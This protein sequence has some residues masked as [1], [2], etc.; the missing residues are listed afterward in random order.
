MMNI[1]VLHSGDMRSISLGGVDR[2]IKSLILFSKDNEVTVFGTTVVGEHIIGEE[3]QKEYRGRKYKFVAISDNARSPLSVFYMLNE[4][5]WVKK[6]GQYD[7]IYAQRTEYSIPFLM[8]KNKK[9][10]I[11]MIHGSS[12]YSEIGFGKKMAKIHLFMEKMAVSIAAKTFII[13]NRE[14]F[15]VP[16]YKKK[17]AK[18]ANR[19]LYGR[20]PIDTSIYKKLDRNMARQQLKLNNDD[21]IVLFSGRVEHNPKR[22][23]FFPDICK[24]LIR[25]V[26]NLKF[27]V[28]GDGKS[29]ESLVEKIEEMNLQENFHLPGYIDDPNLIAIYN[30]AANVTINIS[31]FEGTCTSNLEAIACGVPVVSTDV[32]DIRECIHENYNGI[33][34]PNNDD[35]SI[36]NNSVEAIRY[37]HENEIQ[38][39]DVYKL[40][41]GEKVYD[42]LKEIIRSLL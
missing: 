29:R 18:Y 36:I 1:A 24:M 21:F 35:V 37:I 23:L 17:Y 19:F 9:K 38:M 39:D 27:I 15:G 16:Y 22:V 13:L 31:M 5:K 3:Y 32:G 30:N 10:L 28:I 7:C 4:F 11:E 2:Y 6:I 40:Y 14:E 41:S 8:S 33:I 12:K 26:P 34:I 20:N 25:F 42:D